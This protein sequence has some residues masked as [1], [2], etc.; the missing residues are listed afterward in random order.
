MKD[1]KPIWTDIFYH[2][3]KKKRKP[4][5]SYNRCHPEE[6]TPFKYHRWDDYG[7]ECVR[8]GV[9]KGHD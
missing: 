6:G 4:R 8:C 7:M 9:M 5:P 3:K 2:G 1:S